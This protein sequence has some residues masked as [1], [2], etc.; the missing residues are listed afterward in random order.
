MIRV[1]AISAEEVRKTAELFRIDSIR[2]HSMEAKT[3]TIDTI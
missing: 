1:K 3:R 2:I